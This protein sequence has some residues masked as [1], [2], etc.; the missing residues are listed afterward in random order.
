MLRC[1]LV[2]LHRV[3]VR[4]LFILGVTRLLRSSIFRKSR[5]VLGALL[6]NCKFIQLKNALS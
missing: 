3:A 6:L 4:G 1:H 5:I 2:A